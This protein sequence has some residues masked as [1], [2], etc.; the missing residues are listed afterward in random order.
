MIQTSFHE[1]MKLES[2]PSLSGLCSDIHFLSFHWI[3]HLYTYKYAKPSKEPQVFPFLPQCVVRLG[4]HDHPTLPV[5][6][7]GIS[8]IAI[9]IFMCYD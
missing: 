1:F 5:L 6:L 3:S 4:F 2:G 8:L 7:S 9:V